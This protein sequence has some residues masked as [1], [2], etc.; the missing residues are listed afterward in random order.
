MTDFYSRQEIKH[1]RKEHKCLC[2][3]AII[4]VG[5][6]YIIHAG[7][8]EGDFY[9]Y[10]TCPVCEKILNYLYNEV[11][12]DEFDVGSILSEQEVWEDKKVIELLKQI[13]HPS[14]FVKDILE[15]CK[16][17]QEVEND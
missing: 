3:N 17:H 6:P 1:A 15:E 5:E 2:C 13:K 7:K 8:Y 9:T 10:K 11:G 16:Q 12:Y 4:Q 14:E